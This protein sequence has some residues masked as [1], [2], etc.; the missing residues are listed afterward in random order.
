MTSIVPVDA[1][2]VLL[3]EIIYYG[4]EKLYHHI[5]QVV[6]ET[7]QKK[8]TTPLLSFW[9]AFAVMMEGS[10]ADAMQE[11][12]QLNHRDFI[13][14]TTLALI[15]AHKLCQTVDKDSIQKLEARMR[16]ERRSCGESGLY[17][18]GLFLWMVGRHDKAR[19]YIGRALKASPQANPEISTL[20][21]WINLTC[22]RDS[23]VKT[24]VEYFD[25][26]FSNSEAP[27]PPD[28]FLG[29][30][31]YFEMRREVPGA[32]DLVNLAVVVYRDYLPALL[33]KCRLQLAVHGWEQC[34]DATQRV[35]QQVPTSVI[36]Q[37]YMALCYVCKNG[38]PSK[39]AAKLSE[40]LEA[41]DR[42]EPRN[43]RLYYDVSRVFSRVACGNQ[44]IL[45]QTS[46]LLE[47]ARSL[48][49]AAPDFVIESANQVLM[50]TGKNRSP[51]EALKLYKEAMNLDDASV[52]ALTGITWCQMLLG[53]LDDAAQQLEF[54]A[55]LQASG[56][57]SPELFYLR[58]LLDE[59]K[60]SPVADIVDK[61]C[62]A[63]QCNSEV[64]KG[65]HL[66][67]DYF[68]A[69]HP[70]F[71]L[72]LVKMLFKYA[73]EDS[74]S[75]V[76]VLH[77]CENLLSELT[78]NA[79]GLIEPQYLT[80]KMW[81]LR[82]NLTRA[83]VALVQ[84]LKLDST[85][86][87]ALLL[88]A[89][90]SLLKGDVRQCKQHLEAGLSYNFEVRDSPQFHL[91]QA[92][93]CMMEDNM[94]GAETSLVTALG[95]PGV[96]KRDASKSVTVSERASIFLD[97]VKVY[98]ESQQQVEALKLVNE[99]KELF[100]G[101]TEELRTTVA[102]AD[103]LAMTDIEAALTMLRSIKST[104]KFYIQSRQK[105]AE[106]FLKQRHDKSSY[107]KCFIE[108][109]TT[110]G[111]THAD[112]LL[113]DAYMT[114]KEPGKA[115]EAYQAALRKDPHNGQLACK[116]GKALSRTHNFTKAI[117]YYETAYKVS[118]QA[119]LRSDL[120]ELHLK[121]RQY[122]KVEKLCS[123]ALAA[124]EGNEAESVKE[125]VKYLL[126]LATVTEKTSDQLALS[127]LE[128]AKEEQSKLLRSIKPSAEP[129]SG[130]L[131]VERQRAAD[132]C[133]RSAVLFIKRR[134]HEAA[135]RLFQE[136]LLF[137]ENYEK[138]L[139]ALAELYLSMDN[140]DAC[141]QHCVTILRHAQD[142]EQATMVTGIGE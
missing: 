21:G 73:E 141:Q 83:H 41:I 117:T 62:S 137:V 138:A 100:Q 88:N 115:V 87:P 2:K 71:V 93:A 65:H 89:E 135:V 126:L 43:H 39:C 94:N 109:A 113:G 61:L 116:A 99:A 8:G 77:C 44:L 7:R 86:S 97:L 131:K 13:L 42:Y 80:A 22:G 122:D 45:Q 133:C 124:E 121:L 136:A 79:P 35:L 82:D 53:D 59:K 40:L 140:T 78:E 98:K 125:R 34:L 5:Q 112:D 36:A 91:L 37:Q 114:I 12:Q 46:A 9:N 47:R 118:K 111:S 70:D 104:D 142:H 14:C 19:E 20:Y 52:P 10:L 74:S 4:R 28:C 90:V 63:A 3:N 110:I 68:A 56:A 66:S 102:H 17:H 101:T 132:I 57:E 120:A 81:L 107:I 139:I 75:S 29:K 18:A 33:E 48:Q 123:A 55:E 92:R 127:H 23:L 76:K 64:A 38:D 60:G 11:F 67:I 32:L 31:R 84:C 103:L 15:H 134:D 49:P 6:L 106:I 119:S 54:L 129:A 130:D 27:V 1:D 24:S 30:A 69:V 58:A 95:L 96:R 51:L 26:P 105:M 128:R 108:V 72:R 50:S 85:Y 16:E 25:K